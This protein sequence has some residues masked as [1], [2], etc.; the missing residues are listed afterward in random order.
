MSL[1]RCWASWFAAAFVLGI[2][3]RY[4]VITTAIWQAVVVPAR[5]PRASALGIALA[6][7]GVRDAEPRLFHGPAGHQGTRTVRRSGCGTMAM[8]RLAWVL[9]A[10][11]VAYV[12]IAVGGCQLAGLLQDFLPAP[13]DGDPVAERIHLGQLP[14]RLRFRRGAFGPDQQPHPR[15]G[16][17]PVGRGRRDGWCCR[18]GLSTAG[19]PGHSLVEYVVMFPQAVPRMVFGLALLWAWPG[20]SD[21]D[22]SR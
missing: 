6:C 17:W 2:P 16:E 12:V 4:V 14:D 15:G 7:G 1:P 9:F 18:Y 8:G 21:P 20:D 5:Y 10:A 3:G 11:C 22:P 13:R 19:S